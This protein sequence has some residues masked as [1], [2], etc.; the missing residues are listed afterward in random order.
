ML[1]DLLEVAAAF[2][3][4]AVR[5]HHDQAHPSVALGGIGLARN[6]HQVAVEGAADEG[7]RTVEDVVVA[8]PH[9]GGADAGE[10]GARSSARSWRRRAPGCR[11]RCPGANGP[12]ARRCRPRGSTGCTPRCAAR[13]RCR[14][15]CHPEPSR[16]LHHDRVVTE[17]PGA[18][19]SEL[20]GHVDPEVAGG[21]G[22][23]EQVACRRCRPASHFSLF[24]TISRSRNWANP[25]RNS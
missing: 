17:V 11:R 4:C 18:T 8:V 1:A 22:L 16:L 24:G 5:L 3:A 10:I 19:A 21:A 7:L 2:E 6:D 12:S 15:T 23:A 13:C 14:R 9:G 20:L 25:S